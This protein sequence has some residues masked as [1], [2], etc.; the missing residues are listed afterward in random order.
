MVTTE[1]WI[2]H[3]IVVMHNKEM[4]NLDIKRRSDWTR[5]VCSPGGDAAN[6][7]AVNFSIGEAILL[8]RYWN[9]VKKFIKC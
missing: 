1:F 3:D 4:A 5:I 7:S 2:N 6:K 9:F 8:K